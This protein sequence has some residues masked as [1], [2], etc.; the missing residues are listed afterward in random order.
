MKKN[1]DIA[2]AWR[3]EDYY[4]G[5]TEEERASLGT[6]PAGALA[7]PVLKSITGGCG[8]HTSVNCEYTVNTTG[9]CSVCPPE[10]CE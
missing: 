6:H 8:D 7:D 4:L 10:W 1:V 5:L 2:R 3:D 9:V